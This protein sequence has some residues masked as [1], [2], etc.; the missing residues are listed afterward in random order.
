MAKTKVAEHSYQSIALTPAKTALETFV[1]LH[2]FL[3]L[4]TKLA[5]CTSNH[6]SQ[7]ACYFQ[8][9]RFATRTKT[10]PYEDCTAKYCAYHCSRVLLHLSNFFNKALKDTMGKSTM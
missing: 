6:V 2:R 3:S 9:N 5:L 4:H 10:L 8:L 1:T 7:F